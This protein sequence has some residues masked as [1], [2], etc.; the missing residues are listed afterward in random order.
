LPATS[1]FDIPNLKEWYRQNAGPNDIS[2]RKW[3]ERLWRMGSPRSKLR[4]Q[5]IAQGLLP[6]PPPSKRSRSPKT[7]TPFLSYDGEGRGKDGTYILLANSL[8]DEIYNPNGLS[9]LQCLDFLTKR[10]DQPYIRIFY[11]FG[12]DVNMI[13]KGLPNEYW[14]RI[15]RYSTWAGHRIQY[16]SGKIFRVDGYS[17]YDIL[18]FFARSLS[19]ALKDVLHIEDPIINRGKSMRA[20]L[21]DQLTLD[22]IREYNNRELDRT[23]ELADHLRDALENIGLSL[24]SWYGPGAIAKKMFQ[25]HGIPRQAESLDIPD[26]CYQALE[27]A[28]YGGRFEN[29]ILG[30][31]QTV[32]EYDI[33][34]A[35]PAVIKSLP[36]FR[37]W[38]HAVRYNPDEEF[39]IWKV[40]WDL[41]QAPT[42][43]Q[44]QPLP[45]RS[46]AG[47]LSF[48]LVGKGWYWAPEIKAAIAHYGDFFHITEGWVAET[49]R[50]PFDWVEELYYQ[51]MELKERGDASEYAIKVGINS[52]YGKTAQRV[53]A[54]TYFNIGWAGYITA[55]T[56]SKLLNAYALDPEHCIG[57]ATDAIYSTARIRSLAISEALGDWEEK[58]YPG[59]G[60]FIL[61]GLYVLSD[62]KIQKNRIRGLPSTNAL[63]EMLDGFAQRPYDIPETKLRTFISNRLAYRAPAKYESHRCEFVDVRYALNVREP[64]KRYYDFPIDEHGINYGAILTQQITSKPVIWG[65]EQLHSQEEGTFTLKSEQLFDPEKYDWFLKNPLIDI[66]SSVSRRFAD[67]DEESTLSLMEQEGEFIADI[68]RDYFGDDLPID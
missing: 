38:R 55:A 3:L 35:Y 11:G 14:D 8:G 32:W 20:D 33:H 25:V 66:P 6:P 19:A 64:R 18:P 24:S 17:Y 29:Q 31:C 49:E 52:L 2:Y 67:D 61:P 16:L 53:G 41:R 54:N 57:F 26:D 34:S 56:R 60:I 62:G 23:V 4:K 10:Y 28:Y 63:A 42:R 22:E 44:L 36:I 46:R 39:A 9:T 37:H 43:L 58:H 68:E 45:F 65:T 7:K 51:R 5:L 48:P 15:D 47:R 59:G 1:D 27:N 12:Y 50:T 13:L 40:A 21:F 30:K